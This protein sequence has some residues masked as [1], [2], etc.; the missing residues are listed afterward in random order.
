[1]RR[2]Q[3]TI[4]AGWDVNGVLEGTK[5]DEPSS[6]SERARERERERER[7]MS[8]GSKIARDR[9]RR[10]PRDRE[11][12]SEGRTPLEQVGVSMVSSRAGRHSSRFD[13]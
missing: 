6:K 3:H 8:D 5:V 11:T 10:R 12:N 7:E 2:L 9:K 4:P 1:M 13:Y